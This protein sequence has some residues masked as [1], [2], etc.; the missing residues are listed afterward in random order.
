MCLT[1]AKAEGSSLA[2]ESLGKSWHGWQ[3]IFTAP[4][5]HVYRI[6]SQDVRRLLC[7]FGYDMV[8]GLVLSF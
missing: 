1:V 6:W 3:Q 7:S 4:K 2:V 8:W 5:G